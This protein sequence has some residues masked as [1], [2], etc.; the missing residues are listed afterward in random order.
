MI[1]QC[2]W[3]RVPPLTLQ[4]ILSINT[5]IRPFRVRPSPDPA[6]SFSRKCVLV[7]QWCPTLCYCMDCS[8]PG[9][10][11][12]GILQA[13]TLEWVAISY[14]RESSRPRVRT[15]ISYVSCIVLSREGTHVICLLPT[16]LTSV[17]L[18]LEAH[19]IMLSL[20]G[21]SRLSPGVPS[22]GGHLSPW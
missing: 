7:A 16:P 19:G 18:G 2:P 9:A 20:W 11:V 3:D 4:G 1:P 6:I 21:P 10:S 22:Q 5:M 8:L 15:S 13:R 17:S 14:A 12:H